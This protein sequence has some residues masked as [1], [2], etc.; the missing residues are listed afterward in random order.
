MLPVVGATVDLLLVRH[1]GDV[2]VNILRREGDVRIT[3]VK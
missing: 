2:G 3:I 1:K